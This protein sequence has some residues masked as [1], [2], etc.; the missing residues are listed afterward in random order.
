[1]GELGKLVQL[2]KIILEQ[3]KKDTFR[4]GGTG[5]LR[6]TTR[7]FFGNVEIKLGLFDINYYRQKAGGKRVGSA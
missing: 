5:S 4:E 1:M 6:E 7:A 2:S 3:K